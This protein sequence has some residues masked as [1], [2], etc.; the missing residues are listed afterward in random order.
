MHATDCNDRRVKLIIE[1]AVRGEMKIVRCC[2]LMG[3]VANVS[4]VPL[5]LL[6]VCPAGQ[7]EENNV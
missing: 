6:F 7:R 1:V 3:S 5:N 4:G 2:H